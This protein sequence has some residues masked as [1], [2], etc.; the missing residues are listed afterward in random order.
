MRRQKSVYQGWKGTLG[1][2]SY[3]PTIKHLTDDSEGACDSSW[4]AYFDISLAQ[5]DL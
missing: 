5:C 4:G 3:P 1:L 2:F